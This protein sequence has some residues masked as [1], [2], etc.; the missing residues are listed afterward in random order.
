LFVAAAEERIVIDKECT[1]PLFDK[2]R[3]CSV[4]VAFAAGVQDTPMASA[5]ACKSFVSDL[6]DR[7]GRVD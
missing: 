1:S 3:K 6:G 2:R 4:K 5:T 7:I